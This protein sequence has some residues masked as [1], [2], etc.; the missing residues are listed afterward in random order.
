MQQIKEYHGCSPERFLQELLPLGQPVV[1]RQAV[2]SWSVVKVAQDGPAALLSYLKPFDSGQATDTL[3]LAPD[4]AGRIFYRPDYQGFNFERSRYPLT[5]VLQQLIKQSSASPSLFI[6]LQSA[7]LTRCLPE[8]V[9]QLPLPFLPEPAAG[10]VWLGNQ[11]T[12][13]AH[14]DDGHN[15]AAVVAGR[16]R[17][18]LFPPE[19]VAN[20]YPGPLDFA[21]TGTPISLL[22]LHKPDYQRFPRAKAAL[23][24]AQQTELLPGDVLY[25]PLLW[26]HQVESLSPVSMLINY[27]W[28]GSLSAKPVQP[29]A[30]DSLLFTLLSM[31]HYSPAE[32][33]AWA[34]LFQ[35]FAFSGEETG[36]PAQLPALQHL[37][38]PGQGELPAATRLAALR[39]WLQQ[40][41]ADKAD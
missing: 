14:F 1:L 37:L 16:R 28:G 39:S 9:T 12:V 21:P 3:L 2:A 11:V 15:L 36:I 5:A 10:R 30:F 35:Y 32:R 24:S 40:Q 20:L 27:W 41:L 38:Q 25:I 26:W 8:L 4:T 19:Q 6:A 7:A 33:Q 13:P 29:A 22:N 18:T 31:Q 34:A 23:A 17:F